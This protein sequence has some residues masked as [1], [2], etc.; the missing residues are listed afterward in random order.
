MIDGIGSVVFDG[1]EIIKEIGHGAYGHVYEI[2]KSEY[3]I[4]ALSALKVVRIPS[5]QNE[6]ESALSDGMDIRSVANYFKGFVDELA[7]EIAVMTRLQG[8]PNIVSYQDHH[9]EEVDDGIGWEIL[10]RMELLE[11]L[12]KYQLHNPDI[13]E[14]LVIKL[15]IDIANAL[16]VC[17]KNGI[18]HRDIKPDNIFW[19]KTSEAFKLGDFGVARAL[20]KTTGGLSK[21]GTESYMAPEVYKG[22]AYGKTV[23]IYSLG[24]LLYR[25]ANRNRLPFYP[26][27]GNMVNYEQRESAMIRRM[28][29]EPIPAPCAA[30][31]ELAAIILKACEYEPE[32]R[33]QNA[34]EMKAALEHLQLKKKSASKETGSA[35]AERLNSKRTSQISSE[36]T[37][38]IDEE[39][40]RVR[41]EESIKE[42]IGVYDNR[43][44]ETVGL[45]N[46][47]IQSAADRDQEQ[48]KDKSGDHGKKESGKNTPEYD[49]TPDTV[50]FFRKRKQL[51]S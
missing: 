22:K 12:V 13:S 25:C 33:Y 35:D 34:V 37:V 39:R 30:S 8:H 43:N 32:N 18:I 38:G 6:V 31:P 40:G 29:G 28:N 42:T 51:Q 20:E 9:I 47:S 1:W 17:Q 14:D 10:I 2:R 49:F 5:S 7:G 41:S 11:S 46:E 15:G 48:K 19:D 16:C 45:N 23:D 24:I 4:T 21:K 27:T 26:I 3:G 44:E 36:L 50:R